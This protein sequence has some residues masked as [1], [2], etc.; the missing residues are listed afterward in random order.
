MTKWEK[1]R[2]RLYE[3]KFEVEDKLKE[4]GYIEGEHYLF[5]SISLQGS[6]NYK[7]DTENSDVDSKYSLIPTVKSMLRGTD[8][9]MELTVSKN[10]KV[11]VKAFPDY[12][13]LFFKGNVN[14]LEMLFTDYIVC[15]YSLGLMYDLRTIREEIVRATINTVTSAAIGM[16]LQKQKTMFKGTETTKPYV[17]KLGFDPKD[18]QHI[19]R[20]GLM[21]SDLLSGKSF[22]ESLVMDESF[23]HVRDAMYNGSYSKEAMTQL[24]G[25]WI[26]AVKQFEEVVSPKNDLERIEYLRQKISLMYEDVYDQ[27]LSENVYNCRHC[28]LRGLNE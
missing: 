4:R 20:L 3:H 14:N 27:Y 26:E 22:E 18:C 21:T 7:T 23:C 28:M 19:Y 24:V 9:T 25:G 13:K 16:M 12:V 2:D 5:E 11:S 6:Q 15:N 10:E 8:F 1:I 17:E